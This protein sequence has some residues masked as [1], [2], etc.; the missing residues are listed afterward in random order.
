M[1]DT[2]LLADSI[3]KKISD[4]KD[5]DFPSI[6][7]NVVKKI[8]FKISIFLFF[9]GMFVFSDIFIDNFLPKDNVDGYCADTKGTVMQLITLVLAYIVIDLMVQSE[10]V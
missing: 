8:N 5:T 3:E 6:C 2:E 9:I 7:V 1:S 10:I 4:S